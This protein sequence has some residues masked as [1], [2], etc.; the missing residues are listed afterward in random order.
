MWCRDAAAAIITARVPSDLATVLELTPHGT[1]AWVGPPVSYPWGTR[2]FGG[3]VI[4]QGASR[5]A[6][7]SIPVRIHSMHSYFIKGGTD[8]EPIPVRGRPDPQRPLVLHPACG[9]PPGRRRSSASARPTVREDEPE[10]M[11]ITPPDVPGPE[12]MDRTGWGFILDRSSMWY[13]PGTGRGTGWVRLLDPLPDEPGVAE[14]GLAFTSDTIQ[15]EAARNGHPIADDD[16]DRDAFMGASLDHAI[17]FHRPIDPTEWH[18]YDFRSK[19][20]IGGRGLMSGEVFDQNGVHVASV[21]QE[22]LLRVRR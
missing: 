14:C 21:A 5:C 16:T 15:F 9:R 8:T 22:V 10:A 1:D 7:P 6:P 3:Q 13:P 11:P 12:R 20:H 4:A 17:W 18:L 19:G 2:L